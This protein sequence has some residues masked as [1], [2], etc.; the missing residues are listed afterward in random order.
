M[1]GKDTYPGT[2]F[3]RSELDLKE[4]KCH[5]LLAMLWILMDCVS[6]GVKDIMVQLGSRNR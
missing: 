1:T 4:Q 6:I 2:N 3:T 5:N